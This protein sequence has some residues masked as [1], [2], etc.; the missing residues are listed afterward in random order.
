[1]NSRA[2]LAA[3]LNEIVGSGLLQ[4]DPHLV[5]A[6]RNMDETQAVIRIAREFEHAILPLGT[7]S[8]F[9]DDF[10][11]MRSS[12][13]AVL[14]AGLRGVECTSAFRVRVAAGTPTASLLANDVVCPRSTLGGL[15]CGARKF[16]DQP[17]LAA[18]W[19]RVLAVE[20]LNAAGELQTASCGG[21]ADRK[22]PAHVF[23]GSRGRIGLLTAVHFA[24]PLPWEAS[25]V[26]TDAPP[27]IERAFGTSA[28]TMSDL[29]QL[30]DGNGTYHW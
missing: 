27:G 9:A 11:L 13:V 25:T 28:L 3:A 2:V 19:R 21:R 16:H 30:V 7:G 10:S 26:E 15:I 4:T 24:A 23:L 20:F 29:Q 6:P 5:I 1:M 8:S 12:V 17:A 18:L 22:L 14:C